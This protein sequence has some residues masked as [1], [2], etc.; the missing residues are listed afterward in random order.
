MQ[1]VSPSV[2]GHPVSCIVFASLPTSIVDTVLISLSSWIQCLSVNTFHFMDRQDSGC[3]HTRTHTTFSRVCY[4][5]TSRQAR[6]H[7]RIRTRTSTTLET[8]SCGEGVQSSRSLASRIASRPSTST[9]TSSVCGSSIAA[10]YV[11]V[12]DLRHLGVAFFCCVSL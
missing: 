8:G 6:A 9:R 11:V 2:V 10:R 4:S 12:Q 7:D 3:L 5:G 1:S